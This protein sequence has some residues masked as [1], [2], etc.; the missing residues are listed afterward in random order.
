MSISG[1]GPWK[2]TTIKAICPHLVQPSM[3]GTEPIERVT[4]P[5]GKSQEK[6]ITN[7]DARDKAT[8]TDLLN[9]VAKDTPA[10]IIPEGDQQSFS[11]AQVYKDVTSFQRELA[12]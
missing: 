6:H 9:D 4:N 11:Y 3:L 7:G 5:D 1:A 2:K 10:I 12:C 8:L